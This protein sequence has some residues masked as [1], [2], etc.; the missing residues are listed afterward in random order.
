MSEGALR[1]IIFIVFGGVFCD[2]DFVIMCEF[3]VFDFVVL[4]KK[5]M[6]YLNWDMGAKIT[7]DSATFMNKAFEVIEAYYFYGIFY[8]NIDVIVYL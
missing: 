1:C 7:C 5:V 3:V 6:M 4:Y 2:M 8:D